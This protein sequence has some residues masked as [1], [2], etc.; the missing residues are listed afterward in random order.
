MIAAAHHISV[1]LLHKLFQE[2]GQT[3]A[4]W[5]RARRLEGCQRDLLEPAEAGRP[6]AALAAR[7]GY[8]SA[9]ISAASS[10]PPT[11]SR[12]TNTA[13]PQRNQK[14]RS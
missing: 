14:Q 4:G 9:I 3:V 13:W 12:H 8:R 2:Q 10:A 1:R 7:W 5:I 6:V 11:A